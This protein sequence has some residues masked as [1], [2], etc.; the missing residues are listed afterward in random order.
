VTSH[1]RVAEME[2]GMLRIEAEDVAGAA[3]EVLRGK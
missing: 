3:M 2:P 1:A